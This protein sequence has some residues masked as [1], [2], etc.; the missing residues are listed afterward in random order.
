M[1]FKKKV[2]VA[3]K[4]REDR[5][6]IE[7][8]SKLIQVVIE[9]AKDN[10]EFVNKLKDLSDELKY[11]RPSEKNEVKEYDEVINKKIIDV[12]RSLMK[13]DGNQDKL[14]TDI[15]VMIGYRNAVL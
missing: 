2:K 15:K 6:L 9:L 14:Y 12:K 7:T 11:L 3:D 10:E 1:C 5:E 8:N 13:A 4:V